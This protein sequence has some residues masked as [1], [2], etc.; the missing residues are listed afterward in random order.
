MLKTWLLYYEKLRG[1]WTSSRPCKCFQ[2]LNHFASQTSPPPVLRWQHHH[3][4]DWASLRPSPRQEAGLPLPLSLTGLCVSAVVGS[5]Q[6][7]TLSCPRLWQLGSKRAFLLLE[8]NPKS[9]PRHCQKFVF[10]KAVLSVSFPC[11]TIFSVFLPPRGWMLWH[12]IRH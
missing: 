9:L 11:L 4:F 2:N 6:V 1:P 10:W 8:S 3:S 5:V 7:Q 12:N